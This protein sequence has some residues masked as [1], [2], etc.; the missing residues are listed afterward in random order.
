MNASLRVT[1]SNLKKNSLE[2]AQWIKNMKLWLAKHRSYVAILEF[3]SIIHT[4][5]ADLKAKKMHSN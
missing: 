2:P 1:E 3:K 5:S 4:K